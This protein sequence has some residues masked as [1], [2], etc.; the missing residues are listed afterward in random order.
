MAKEAYGF[1]RDGHRRVSNATEAVENQ[2]FGQQPYRRNKKW[3]R[4]RGG[5][6]GGGSSPAKITSGGPGDT[7]VGNIYD[8]GPGET[9]T[10][11]AVTIK[12]LQI[13]SGETIPADT[14]LLVT[15]IGSVYWG[16]IA[17]WL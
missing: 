5:G 13:D 1:D 14:W 10:A 4:R 2:P 16:Q 3:K 12:I 8:N 6:V 15:L 17:V 7:Y 11:T 9:A